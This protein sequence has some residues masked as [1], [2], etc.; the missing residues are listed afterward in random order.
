MN[1]LCPSC[2]TEAESGFARCPNCGF[3][4]AA[5]PGQGTVGRD[6]TTVVAPPGSG[7]WGKTVVEPAAPRPDAGRRARFDRG[8]EFYEAV[9]ETRA[10]T[11]I[12]G[13]TVAGDQTVVE[14]PQRDAP[15]DATVIVRGGRKGVTGPLAYLVERS[16]VRAGKVHLLRTETSIGRGPDNDVTLGDDS[17]S[18]R[19]AKVR[20][21][22]GKFVYW[23]LASAN[24]S[25][26]V[27]ADGSRARVLEPRQLA[28][29][30]KLDLGEARVTFIL[31]DGGETSDES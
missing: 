25:Y 9:D 27:A 24:Y 2:G 5:A 17:V 23:D 1:R 31:V 8:R 6:G 4:L 29:G 30:D 18:R 19:H 15:D 26:L 13:S 11:A 7:E 21:E 20:L 3:D 12:S 22:E 10:E 16:G 28:D 14:R